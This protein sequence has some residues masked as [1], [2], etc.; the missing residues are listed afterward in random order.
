M[1]ILDQNEQEVLNRAAGAEQIVALSLIAGL[2]H[3]GRPLSPMVMDTPFGRLDTNHR[4]NILAYLPKS[5][6]QLIL[7]VHNGEIRGEEDLE[8]IAH[9]IGGRYEIREVTPTHSTLV[10]S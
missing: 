9:R 5:A 1:T 8:D 10:R 2:T 6:S 4:R 3:A 7:F